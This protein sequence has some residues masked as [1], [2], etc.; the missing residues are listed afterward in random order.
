MELRGRVTNM[1]EFVQHFFVSP[2]GWPTV[3]E[4]INEAEGATPLK[5]W[6]AFLKKPM[7]LKF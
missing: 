4:E 7:L 3:G 5:K 6:A 2:A 1:I